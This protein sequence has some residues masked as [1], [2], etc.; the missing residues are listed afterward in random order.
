MRLE[1]VVIT[2]T[3]IKGVAPVGSKAVTLTRDD[4]LAHGAHRPA[5]RPPRPA[6]GGGHSAPSRRRGDYREGGTSAYGGNVTRGHGDRSARP[7]RA[8]HPDS[9]GWPPDPPTGTAGVFT[10]ANQ[11][12]LAALGRIE[13][14]ADGNSAIYGSDAIGGVV[15]FVMRAGFRRPRSDH[16]RHVRRRL[17]ASVRRV[18]HGRDNVAETSALSGRG[19]V[20]PGV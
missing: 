13:I 8:G 9:G 15:N 12:P 6:A 14:T 20:D 7:R 3:N 2:G 17:Q 11:L 1:E 18:A 5:L 10:E 4:V 19:N 16:A